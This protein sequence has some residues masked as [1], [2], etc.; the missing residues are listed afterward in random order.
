VF[1]KVRKQIHPCLTPFRSQELQNFA[2][3]LT[4]GHVGVQPAE[5][6]ALQTVQVVLQGGFWWKSVQKNPSVSPV[7][8]ACP[9]PQ[10]WTLVLPSLRIFP[11][12]RRNWILFDALRG[13]VEGVGKFYRTVL[14]PSPYPP[15][16]CLNGPRFF[17][18]LLF[19]P[20]TAAQV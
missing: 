18:C 19:F 4:V 10:W 14:P 7:V 13:A 3:T 16:T 6:S 1:L 20:P 11:S 15:S 12:P 8:F 2:R 17:P 9:P 5:G